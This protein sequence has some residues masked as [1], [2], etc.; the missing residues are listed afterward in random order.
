MLYEFTNKSYDLGNASVLKR[1]RNFA[2]HFRRE[3]FSSLA[4]EIWDLVPNSIKEGKNIIFKNKIKGYTIIH[5]S[6]AKII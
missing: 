1:N 4:Q 2:V 5:V 3:N 6:L